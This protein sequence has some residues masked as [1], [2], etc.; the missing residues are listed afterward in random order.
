VRTVEFAIDQ[1]PGDH[2][3]CGRRYAKSSG[4]TPIQTIYEDDDKT[5]YLIRE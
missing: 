4:K 1:E 2:N 3:E 5:K